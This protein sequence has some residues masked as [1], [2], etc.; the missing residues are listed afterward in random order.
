MKRRVLPSLILSETLFA[1][2]RVKLA[3]RRGFSSVVSRSGPGIAHV[4][5][6]HGPLFIELLSSLKNREELLL[7]GVHSVNIMAHVASR[8]RQPKINLIQLGRRKHVL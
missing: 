4:Q 7:G 1:E 8:L 5:F 6:V 2:L 3:I